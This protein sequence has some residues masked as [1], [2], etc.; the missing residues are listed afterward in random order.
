M[1]HYHLNA[2]LCKQQL[3]TMLIAIDLT[4]CC[5]PCTKTSSSC[6]ISHLDDSATIALSR[7]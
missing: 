4:A 3:L 5:L 2:M 1:T 7:K 6:S